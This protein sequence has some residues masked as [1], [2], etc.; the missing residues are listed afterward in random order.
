[1]GPSLSTRIDSTSIQTILQ[2]S[3]GTFKL[4]VP[5]LYFGIVDVRDVALAHIQAGLLESA[6]GRHIL[7]K[8]SLEMM[9]IANIIKNK[10]PSL[11]TPILKVP[12]FLI[13]L[14][15]PI[16][17]FTRY[18]VENNIGYKPIFDNSYTIQDLKMQLR[19]VKD[20]IED[21]VEQLIKDSLLKL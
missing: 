8:D 9:E 13:W 21:H 4:G 12:Y 17:G 14:V 19:D 20:T 18:W 5:E 6:K 10:Y 11:P 16:L 1:M 2:L 7:C 15:S 3:N